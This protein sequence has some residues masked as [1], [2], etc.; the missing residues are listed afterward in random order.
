MYIFG[1]L[2]KLY[3]IC[4]F[5]FKYIDVMFICLYLMNNNGMN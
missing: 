3:L 2:I 4:E 1:K 5:F